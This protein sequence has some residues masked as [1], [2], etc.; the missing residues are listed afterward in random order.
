[1][2][3]KEELK[4]LILSLTPEEL[5]KAAAIVR[6]YVFEFNKG[7]ELDEQKTRSNWPSWKNDRRTIWIVLEVICGKIP[8]G[9]SETYSGYQIEFSNLYKTR[10]WKEVH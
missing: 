4:Q 1:M 10:Y 9:L 6:K 3:A 2:S 8:E 5:E 7:G